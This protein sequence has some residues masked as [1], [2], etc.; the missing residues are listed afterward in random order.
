MNAGEE[1]LADTEEAD[2]AG[3]DEELNDHVVLRCLTVTV[4]DAGITPSMVSV[5][6][7]H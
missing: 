4:S 7:L 3:V 2:E 5:H 6:L 1:D